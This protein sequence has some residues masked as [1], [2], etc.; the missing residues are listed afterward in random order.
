M[1][2]GLK[3]TTEDT[4]KL[5]GLILFLYAFYFAITQLQQAEKRLRENEEK[6]AEKKD[7]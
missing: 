7:W 1:F 3:W 5:L 2:F 4:F 6:R